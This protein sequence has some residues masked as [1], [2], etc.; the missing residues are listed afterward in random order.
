M[1]LSSNHGTLN[2]VIV[3]LNI[4]N[5]TCPIDLNR[6]INCIGPWL[7]WAGGYI[8][9]IRESLYDIRGFLVILATII[10]GV[11]HS[12]SIA[13]STALPTQLQVVYRLGLLGDFDADVMESSGPVVYIIFLSTTAFIT[14]MMLNIL[15]AVISDTYDRV[16][17][18]TAC[19]KPFRTP[20]IPRNGIMCT[21]VKLAKF[22]LVAFLPSLTVSLYLGGQIYFLWNVVHFEAN[23]PE[24]GG[25][26]NNNWRAPR[27]SQRA[28]QQTHQGAHY[29]ATPTE[30]LTEMP[31]KTP[32]KPSTRLRRPVRRSLKGAWQGWARAR[33]FLVGVL[34]GILAGILVGVWVGLLWDPLRLEGMS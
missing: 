26:E 23:L 28:P 29:D 1:L 4:W 3:V 9:M 18:V 14:I 24:F 16:Q 2:A 27:V 10:I 5:V 34:A 8:K 25:R 17:D 15:I 31:T 13:T 33:G 12:F 19:T 22:V 20:E 30:T 32:V 6:T 11:A 7:R 21:C